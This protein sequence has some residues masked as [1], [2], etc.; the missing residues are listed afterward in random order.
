MVARVTDEGQVSAERRA[1]D[2]GIPPLAGFEVALHDLD[3][4]SAGGARWR[5]D[6]CSDA[7]GRDVQEAIREL[8]SDD[9]V[10]ARDGTALS[11]C[12][13]GEGHRSP[14]LTWHAQAIAS[15]VE[16][17]FTPTSPCLWPHLDVIEALLR[18]ENH[19][20][21]GEA[22]S[23]PEERSEREGWALRCRHLGWIVACM[24]EYQPHEPGISRPGAVEAMHSGEA[25][26]APR[27][28]DE[29][30]RRLLTLAYDGL[31]GSPQA[32]ISPSR[33][34]APRRD[35]FELVWHEFWPTGDPEQPLERRPNI[36]STVYAIL[37]LCRA[38]RHGFTHYHDP[39]HALVHNEQTPTALVDNLLTQV[40]VECSAGGPT[41]QLV[42]QAQ[43]DRAP[44]LW[45][46]PWCTHAYTLPSS[47]V[48]LL[49]LT[50]VEYAR[51]LAEISTDHDRTQSRAAFLKAQ[52]LA[53]SLIARPAFTGVLW[54]RAADAFFQY[55]EDR[56]WFIPT[57]SVCVR[58]L[59]ETGAAG[60]THPLVLDAF[61]T[62]K[63]LTLPADDPRG[64]RW[65]DATYRTG[66]YEAAAL[67]AHTTGYS[68]RGRPEQEELP[69]A[70]GPHGDRDEP[71]S[72]HASLD[73]REAALGNT[74]EWRA[75]A[76][77][78]H[79]A[80]LAYSA[81]RRAWGRIDPRTPPEVRDA[82]STDPRENRRAIRELP[83][84]PFNEIVFTGH[85]KTGDTP[86]WHVT[87]IRTDAAYRERAQITENTTFTLLRALHE[88]QADAE[89]AGSNPATVPIWRLQS[90]LQA[91]DSV[92]RQRIYRANAFFG[93]ELIRRLGRG[94]DEYQLDP[95]A[96][97]TFE[98]VVLEAAAETATYSDLKR[99]IGQRANASTA[100]RR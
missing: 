23:D 43:P 47:V 88:L 74:S 67:R 80:A 35:Q 9:Q 95:E 14:S 5:G 92:I 58:A 82:N 51:F 63:A 8:L 18:T 41:I 45:T 33:W 20:D 29:K 30:F 78:V 79:A 28:D 90:R 3:I 21:P 39:W 97:I 100:K 4:G 75:T 42:D 72:Q 56:A 11:P 49:A 48:G 65:L 36:L 10:T 83:R 86:P 73:V 50:L 64:G 94:S 27:W 91:R 93:F 31:V 44:P 59:L 98:S 38:E 12:L 46:E 66:L 60:P 71:G 62:I 77:S 68:R 69:P 81:M 17:G 61:D 6:E 25:R 2:E 40:A 19:C 53:Q 1:G 16:M 22:S 87:L 89:G 32:T 84:C 34:I 99:P 26:D 7:L 13:L 76:A 37:A 52:R 96:R 70:Y 54:S 85:G 15:L 55:G 24:S 57:Y